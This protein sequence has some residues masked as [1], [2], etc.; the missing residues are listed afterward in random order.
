M[1]RQVIVVLPEL[2]LDAAWRVM[3]RENIRHLPVV[4]GGELIG[5]LS[6]RDVLLRS[7]GGR[8]GK[9][10]VPK[11]TVGE[12][13]TPAPIVCTAKESLG[14]LVRLMTEHRIDAVPIVTRSKRL[15]GLVTTT[16]LLFALVGFEDTRP[17]PIRFEIRH[18]DVGKA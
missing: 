17:L 12:A 14:H 8:D 11:T 13:M 6:D 10:V 3:Q 4:Q 5:M 1:T 2:A 16:D 18:A 9:L 15:L 7:S